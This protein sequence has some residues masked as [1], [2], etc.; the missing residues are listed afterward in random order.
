MTYDPT[1]PDPACGLIATVGDADQHSQ[2]ARLTRALD[3]TVDRLSDSPVDKLWQQGYAS[4]LA[5]ALS[6][7]TCYTV[8]EVRAQVVL[9]RKWRTGEVE[10]PG[11]VAS[12]P[13][14]RP[15]KARR[16]RS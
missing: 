5:Y 4:G 3:Q 13:P 1:S 15:R 7:C 11:A 10:R 8:D 12:S 6:I 14:A 2:I 16:K 9:R